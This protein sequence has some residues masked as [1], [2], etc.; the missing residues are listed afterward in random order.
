M[1]KKVLAVLCFSLSFVNRVSFAEISSEE[2][3][4]HV[5]SG[6]NISAGA[7]FVIQGTNNANGDDLSGK[8]EDITDAS[9]SVDIEFEKELSDSDLAYLH[10][11]AADGTGVEDELKVF[12]NVNRDAGDSDNSVEVTEIWYK[13]TF[14]NIQASLMAGKIDGTVLVDTNEYANDECTQFVGRLFRNSPTIE[15]PDN[16]AGLHF[17]LGVFDCMEIAFLIMDG[18]SDLEDIADDGFYALQLNLKPGLLEHP[19]NY[20]I[21]GWL[22]DR[23]HTKWTDTTRTK[24]TS[25]GFGI[26]FD[27]EITDGLGGFLRYGWQ[28][29]DVYLNGESFSLEHA[30]SAGIQ[31]SGR[32]WERE[33]DV[34]GVAIG[35]IYPSDEYKKAGTNLEANCETH[36]ELY[37]NYSVNEHLTLTPDLQIIWNPY[38]DDASNG[39]DTITVVGIKGQL[40]L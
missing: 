25:Y 20:R 1:F 37:Y 40:D 10:L 38:V 32:K 30:W 7:T 26:S 27:Q 23:E 22:S 3:G 36:L 4:K 17:D 5:L 28:D 15:F 13:H 8:G 19:G 11:E 34:L 24:E 14:E 21:L 2:F 33:R 9:Y 16:T 39:N 6:M 29:P 35:G 18:D 31:L 12:S